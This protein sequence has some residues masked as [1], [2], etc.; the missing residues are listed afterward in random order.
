MPVF[1]FSG[2]TSFKVSNNK[3]EDKKVNEVGRKR[4]QTQTAESPNNT[5]NS[6]L[7]EENLLVLY[8]H[9]TNECP[10]CDTKTSYPYR[11]MC[12]QI[13]KKKNRRGEDI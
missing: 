11:W 10:G 12:N 13:K 1:I 4:S 7:P 3:K 6:P 2:F 9:P 5:N 8:N